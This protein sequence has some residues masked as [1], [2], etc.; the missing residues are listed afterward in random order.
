MKHNKK[1]N[2]G[3]IY[4]TLSR[5]LTKA[6]VDNN[7]ARK[8]EVVNVIKEYFKK[9]TLLSKEL[10]LYNVLLETV[11]VDE[12]LAEKMLT[13]AKRAHRELN[14]KS[15]FDEQSRV[16]SVINKRLGQESW[17][18]FVPN[19]KSLASVSAIFNN[20]TS[21]K[22]RVLF[23]RALVEKMSHRDR[24]AINNELTPL[25]NIA[26]KS[27]IEKF[28]NKYSELLQEQKNLLNHYI[29]SFSDGGFELRVH[30]NEEL[31][32][33]KKG[34]QDAQSTVENPA[35]LEKLKDVGEYLENL[36]K[37]EFS[38]TDLQKIL[39]TQQLMREITLNDN[40]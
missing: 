4:E 39:K 27:F 16:I 26:Y 14:E 11:G 32:R 10:E 7:H 6:I 18:T 15:L 17:S 31:S 34:V 8:A 20:K 40:N 24:G 21:V 25:D 23:E 22:K 9:G 28:N 13:E 1:R 35:I 38:D 29:T 19:F 5:E 30:L 2:T 12:T 33:L 37:R 3:F 36:R